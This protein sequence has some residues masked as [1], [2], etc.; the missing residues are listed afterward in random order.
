MKT[1]SAATGFTHAHLDVARRRL[2]ESTDQADALEAIRE[3]VTNF[4]GSEEMAL[5]KVDTGKAALVPRWSFGIEPQQRRILDS[6]NDQ[7]LQR[8]LEGELYVRDRASQEQAGG[9]LDQFSALVPIRRGD[10]IVAVLGIQE[11]LIQKT[12]IEES[13][14]A[15]LHLLSREAGKALFAQTVEI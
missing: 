14:V 12:Q 1:D 5:F 3:I 10:K 6:L 8:V 2:Q 9:A 7:A 15:L 13:D 4:I 11:L